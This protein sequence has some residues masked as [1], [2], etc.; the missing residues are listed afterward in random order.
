[1]NNYDVEMLADLASIMFS[2]YGDYNPEDPNY[3]EEIFK[4]SLMEAGF[5]ETQ[6]D[7]FIE[8]YE[9]VHQRPN[10]ASG[11]S[12]TVFWDKIDQKYVM[13]F[14]GSELES[15]GPIIDWVTTNFQGICRRG[16]AADQAIDMYRHVWHL[17]VERNNS[18]A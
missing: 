13:A 17:S 6:A 7:D 8:R 9:V 4:A 14:R 11:F 2:S 1:M 18:C 12:A 15:F 5:T 16:Y 10:T 3:S